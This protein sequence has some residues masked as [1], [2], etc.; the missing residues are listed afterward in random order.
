MFI[1]LDR[2]PTIKVRQTSSKLDEPRKLAVDLHF[3]FVI[4]ADG[5][6][7]SVSLDVNHDGSSTMEVQHKE[8]NLEDKTC[9]QIRQVVTVYS[10]AVVKRMQLARLEARTPHSHS[11]ISH[12]ASQEP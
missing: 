7:R 3:F 11:V 4:N 10:T 8:P 12:C 9:W 1:A 5:P 2:H 6:E